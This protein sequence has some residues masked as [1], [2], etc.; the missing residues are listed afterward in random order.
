M[1]GAVGWAAIVA[2]G[3]GSPTPPEVVHAL[4]QYG[5]SQVDE[6]G[7]FGWYIIAREAA[8]AGEI[9][10]AFDALGKALSYWSN[11][12]FWISNLWE[13]DTYWGSLRENQKFRQAFNERRQR[14]GTIH[15]QIHYFP[16]W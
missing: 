10:K 8:H 14:I 11:P 4:Q 12:P 15:G 6:Y 9:I 13:K 16:G 2:G 7:M 5:V 3:S 1:Q